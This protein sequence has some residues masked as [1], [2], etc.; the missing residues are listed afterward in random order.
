MEVEINNKKYKLL[1][2]YKNNKNMYL[3]IKDDLSINITA[4]LRIKEK[5][6]LKFIEDNEEKINKMILKK[7]KNK[8][9]DDE[10]LFLGKKYNICYI[11]EKYPS[12]GTN[13]IFISKTFNIEKWY[14]DQ[15]K[16]IFKEQLD[17]CFNDFKRNIPYPK[18]KIRKMKTR[19]G[20]CNI[21]DK[22]ITL[23][24]E[25]IKMDLK[26]LDYVIYHELSHLIYPNH[27][28]EFWSLVEDHVK[29]YKKYRKEMKKY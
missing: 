16:I 29:D 11:N 13:K 5:E 7:E 2:E 28:K 25:L 20:V 4:P 18:L 6:I 24:L 26:Y 10:I 21:K 8:I 22:T 14:K 9:K 1:V 12:L 27:Q 17:S 23:N 19:W 3:R 15:A